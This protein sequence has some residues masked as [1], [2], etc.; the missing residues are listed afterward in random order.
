MIKDKS[1]KIF[2]SNGVTLTVGGKERIIINGEGGQTFKD[3][4]DYLEMR[5]KDKDLPI[6][7]E[8]VIDHTYNDGKKERHQDITHKYFIPVDKVTWFMIEEV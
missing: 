7:F 5:I 6:K 4:Y 3:L 8:V 1:L 2:L